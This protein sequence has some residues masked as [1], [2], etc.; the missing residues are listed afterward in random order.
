MD[1]TCNMSRYRLYSF[2]YLF[3]VVGPFVCCCFVC[4]LLLFFRKNIYGTRNFCRYFLFFEIKNDS[5]SK[6]CLETPHFK[7][8][9]AKC[10]AYLKV[11]TPRAK[12]LTIATCI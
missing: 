8:F 7:H 10:V 2:L 1:I 5:D 9:C 3:F 11:G 4:S 12:N 6:L